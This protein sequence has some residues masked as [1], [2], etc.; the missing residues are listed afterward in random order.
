VLRSGLDMHFA[1]SALLEVCANLMCFSGT[2]TVAQLVAQECELVMAPICKGSFS[3]SIN[4]ISWG[5]K[6]GRGNEMLTTDADNLL[7][8]AQCNCARTLARMNRTITE[9]IRFLNLEWYN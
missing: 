3:V 5:T 2:V 7:V 1:L 9:R 4:E 6:P 8:R